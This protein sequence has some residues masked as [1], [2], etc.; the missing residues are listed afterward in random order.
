MSKQHLREW[1]DSR[2]ASVHTPALLACSRA[3]PSL[4]SSAQHA[5]PTVGHQARRLAAARAESRDRAEQYIEGLFDCRRATVAWACVKRFRKGYERQLV[6]AQVLLL[7]RARPSVRLLVHISRPWHEPRAAPRAAKATPLNI[8]HGLSAGASEAERSSR[9]SHPAPAPKSSQHG[10]QKLK[11]DLMELEVRRAQP[12]L[13]LSNRTP[14]LRSVL[15]PLLATHTLHAPSVPLPSGA[16][17]MRMPGRTT[18]LGM[19]W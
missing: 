7:S 6:G 9:A 13:S 8:A 15:P 3:E 12:L 5:K 16:L 2:C 11:N 1:I 19:L 10:L 4:S 18:S 17:P 14:Q